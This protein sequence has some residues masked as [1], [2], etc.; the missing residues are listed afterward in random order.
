MSF[1]DCAPRSF[2]V[3]SIRKNAPES[4]GVYGL[5]NNRDWLFIGE[6][7]NI[8]A[9]LLEHL[10]EVNTPL[11][12]QRP[13]GFAYEVCSLPDSITRQRALSR[14]LKPVCNGQSDWDTAS[15]RR[16]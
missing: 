14:H 8:R 2:T 1:S 15:A 6:T 3:V 13:T 11:S 16:R 9:S 10:N 4:A 5:S 7:N 12:A